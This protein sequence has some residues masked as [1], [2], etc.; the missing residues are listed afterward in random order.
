MRYPIRT[1]ALAAVAV[2]LLTGCSVSYPFQLVLM[3][4]SDED[5]RPIEGATVVLDTTDTV[6]HEGKMDYGQGSGKSDAGGQLLHD[7]SISQAPDRYAHWYLKIQ[8]PDF[9]PV[10]ID[11]RP[12]P[13][14]K[15]NEKIQIPVSVKMKP[16]PK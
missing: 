6:E 3:V 11:I 10:V 12:N 15:S 5:G 1:L 2:T 8:H 9:E 16:L 4:V 7:F 14:P 13:V